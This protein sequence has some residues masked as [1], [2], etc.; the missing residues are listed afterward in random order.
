MALVTDFKFPQKFTLLFPKNMEAT[1][2]Y[3]L[4]KVFTQLQEYK[5]DR[6]VQRLIT[7]LKKK[8]RSEE[9]FSQV[10]RRGLLG[11]EI[12]KILE[13]APYKVENFPPWLTVLLREASNDFSP[14]SPPHQA[15][16]RGWTLQALRD[17]LSFDDIDACQSM[18]YSLEEIAVY[19]SSNNRIKELRRIAKTFSEACCIND[20]SKYAASRWAQLILMDCVQDKTI[21][22]ELFEVAIKNFPFLKTNVEFVRRHVKLENLAKFYEPK[23]W[24][25]YVDSTEQA[26]LTKTLLPSNYFAVKGPYD[27]EFFSFLQSLYTHDLLVEYLPPRWFQGE[28]LGA[29][30]DSK[31]PANTCKKL[32]QDK[33]FKECLTFVRRNLDIVDL[34]KRFRA[35]YYRDVSKAEI[36]VLKKTIRNPSEIYELKIPLSRQQRER[37]LC[38]EFVNLLKHM[39][40][41]LSEFVDYRSCNVYPSHDLTWKQL[42]EI[43]SPILRISGERY[44]SFS[45]DDNELI[46]SRDNMR[47]FFRQHKLLE[48]KLVQKF[49]NTVGIS[50]R[51][52]GW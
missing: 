4:S 10:K 1:L 42:F 21:T 15:K 29:V 41:K 43:C 37:I 6:T 18:G 23:F 35:K 26:F 46:G 50:T 40:F 34:V 8:G 36:Q 38:P 3:N 25:P 9:F 28:F 52:V 49:C 45:V 20:L 13:Y 19:L 5:K 27:P 16:K 22:A 31:V 39:E 51:Q 30:L 14:A 11:S 7:L 48:N 24:V 47:S 32:I 12:D 17:L 2:D 33:R 44:G